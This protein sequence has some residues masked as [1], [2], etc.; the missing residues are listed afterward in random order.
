[1]GAVTATREALAQLL[2][3]VQPGRVTD[4]E[5]A[6]VL[7]GRSV[8][9]GRPTFTTRP[10]AAGTFQV[11]IPIVFVADGA[12]RSAQAWLDDSVETAWEILVGAGHPVQSAVPASIATGPIDPAGNQRT[13]PGAVLTVLA[14]ARY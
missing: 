8:Y 5:P 12:A 3:T 6:D 13:S 7:M 2:E 1:M 4:H 14:Y 9:L 10:T 11:A